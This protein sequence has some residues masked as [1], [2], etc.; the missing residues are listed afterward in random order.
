[1]QIENEKDNALE[2]IR[3]SAVESMAHCQKVMRD[4]RDTVKKL[5]EVGILKSEGPNFLVNTAEAK[6]IIWCC[7]GALRDALDSCTRTAEL[8]KRYQ[9][10]FEK[11]QRMEME[12][13]NEPNDAV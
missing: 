12:K 10:I 2:I 6:E 7:Q 8:A 4:M 1:M 11:R 5:A 3:D 13:K 9:E